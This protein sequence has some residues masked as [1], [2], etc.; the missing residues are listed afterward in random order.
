VPLAN[1]DDLHAI[2]TLG[3]GARHDE[4]SVR[5]L[6]R[7]LEEYLASPRRRLAGFALEFDDGERPATLLQALA[8]SS[9]L[10][11]TLDLSL[12]DAPEPGPGWEYL[13]PF[14]SLRLGADGSATLEAWDGSPE[15]A[16]AR[17]LIREHYRPHPGD[18][19]TAAGASTPLEPRMG[20][21]A[22]P[23]F[24]RFVRETGCVPFSVIVALYTS[25][26]RHRIKFDLLDNG[27]LMDWRAGRLPLA[28]RV[29]R[30]SRQSFALD[31]VVARGEF[32]IPTARVLEV[33]AETDGL[34]PV[35]LAHIF[36]GARELVTAALETLTARRLVVS[37]RR[38][39]L[40]RATVD[41]ARA[42][43]A[44]PRAAARGDEAGVP[45]LVLPHLRSGVLELLTAA[46]ARAVCPLCGEPYPDP[47]GRALVCPNCARLIDSEVQQS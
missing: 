26:E 42:A 4:F 16:I 7:R 14:H 22:L 10:P 19:D 2:A 36:G 41:A 23:E 13:R 43:S 6:E 18:I 11:E 25:E 44:G 27:V 5:A 20:L 3:G 12:L 33:L 35:D 38:T 9:F 24:F 21:F 17:I 34:T 37:D 8:D 29:R 28:R 31:S 40:Y 1:R 39:G 30:S 15:R 46:E 47:T 32:S 45:T